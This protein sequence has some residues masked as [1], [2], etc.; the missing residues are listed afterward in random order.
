[1]AEIGRSP[2]EVTQ[3]GSFNPIIFTGTSQ[4]LDVGFLNHQQLVVVESGSRLKIIH[5]FTNP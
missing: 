3:V 4:V 2:L 5:G 1:M